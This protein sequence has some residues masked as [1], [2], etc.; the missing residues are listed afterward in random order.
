VTRH[1]GGT[2]L[3]VSLLDCYEHKYQG[4]LR[5]VTEI[6]NAKVGCG[7]DLLS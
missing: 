4:T 7:F 2:I 6:K 1:Y 5:A 3:T